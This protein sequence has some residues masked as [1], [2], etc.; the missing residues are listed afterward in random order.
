MSVSSTRRLL[1]GVGN[2]GVTVLDL[3][4]VEK[5]GF[6][7][8]LCVNN[9]PESLSAS[10]VPEQLAVPE[11]DPA[12][13]FL[14]IDRKFGDMVSGATS[15]VFCGGLGGESG[16]FLLPAL[17]ILAKSSGITVAACVGMPFSFE[18]KQK[19]ELAA[20]ALEK[21]RTVCDAVVVIENE[22]LTG[23]SP[24]TSA[25]G[26]AFSLSDRMLLSALQAMQGMLSSSGPVKIT[27]GDIKSVLG[28]L[29]QVTLF[30]S[31]TAQGPNR[32]H[33]ALERAL[34]SPL[35]TAPGKGTPG[36]AL[37]GASTVLLLLSGPSDL[38]FAEVQVAVAE[39]ER[40]AGENCQIKT[41]VHADLPSDDPITL[42]ITAGSGTARAT[43]KTQAAVPSQI[44]EAKVAKSEATSVSRREEDASLVPAFVEPSRSASLAKPAKAGAGPAKAAKQPAGK[45]TQGT[46]DLDNYQRGRFDK[47]E[48]TIVA[49]EDLDVPTF[50][51]KGIKLTPPHRN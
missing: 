28:V 32:L 15:V 35:L 42:S 7:G 22:R 29:G 13:G 9:D 12:E 48:P 31:G 38:S 24:S 4:A 26:E 47:S 41:A 34:R 14:A 8:M 37:A 19:R 43:E 46:L 40:I 33:D 44:P 16:S 36:G 51:R 45:Q 2:S 11:G 30:G 49:G 50:L 25:V 1:I 3:L 18:G 5:P 6:Q 10:V 20:K 23:G 27:R 39:I 17:A 21:L